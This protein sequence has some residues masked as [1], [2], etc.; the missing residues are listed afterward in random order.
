MLRDQ[1]RRSCPHPLL[2][3]GGRDLV[4]SKAGQQIMMPQRAWINELRRRQ[5][6]V[7]PPLTRRH[8]PA[9]RPAWR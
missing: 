4:L 8:A 6:S 2:L 7:L 1:Q 9:V 3:L 5:G